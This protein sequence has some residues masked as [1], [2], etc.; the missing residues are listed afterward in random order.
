MVE[1]IETQGFINGLLSKVG[2]ILDGLEAYFAEVDGIR[3]LSFVLLVIAIILFLLSF[4]AIGIHRIMSIIKSGSSD[5]ASKNDEDGTENIFNFEDEDELEKELQRELEFAANEQ[6]RQE[7]ELQQLE[8][9]ERLEKENK[10]RLEKKQKEKQEKEQLEKKEREKKKKV[11]QEKEL[12]TFKEHKS[13]KESTLELDWKKGVNKDNSNDQLDDIESLS[14][15]Y[16]Q[17]SVELNNLMGLAID[18]LGRGVDELKIA[19]TLNFK[20]QGMSDENEILKAI[21]AL[22]GFINLSIKGKFAMLENYDELPNEDQALFHL[23]NGDSSLALAL[24]ENLMDTSIDKANSSASEEK[25]QKMYMEISDYAC[26]FGALA[27]MNDIMLA[28]SSYELAIELQST[29]VIAWGRL[30][31]VYKKA[32]ST[33]KAIWAY[34]NVLNFADGEIDVAQIANANKNISEQLYAEGNSLQAAK[35]YNSSKQYYDS[36]GINRRL[37]KKEVEI[38]DII[39]HNKDTSLP[40]MI[41]KLLSRDRAI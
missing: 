24:L 2:E 17:S 40:D 30:G 39:E 6:Q 19:Q 38:I 13:Y 20:N 26:C 15:S 7:L 34:Q 28:T 5:K 9:K 21:D 29:N 16:K 11:Q 23:A 35:L 33:S 14:L 18:M 32:N 31:D 27:E 36:L 12:N 37:D 10:E 3:I 1:Q 22:K 25:R 8:E 4:I 41:N